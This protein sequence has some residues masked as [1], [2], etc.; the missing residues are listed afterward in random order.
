MAADL[1]D[2]PA[3]G[4]SVQ[5]CGEL[6]HSAQLWLLRHPG[7]PC[8]LRHQR[9]GRDPA[10]SLGVGCKTPNRQLRPW[11]AVTNGFSKDCARDAALTCVRSYRERMAKYS[12]MLTMDVWYDSIGLGKTAP[13]GQGRRSPQGVPKNAWR[14]PAN[15]ACSNMSFPNWF[16]QPGW[17]RRS[18]KIRRS[19][20][21]GANRVTMRCR[22][23]SKGL[24]RLSGDPPGRTGVFFWIVS[25][26]WTSHSRW[27]AS[28]RWDI[29]RHATFRQPPCICPIAPIRFNRWKQHRHTLFTLER[30]AEHRNRFTTRHAVDEESRCTNR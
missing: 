20:I 25:R 5:A 7:T 29:V 18:R 21:T 15:A 17:P 16:T 10:R 3:S 26:S 22:Q 30:L 9:P 28:Q 13:D 24:C 4:L 6:L 8:D 12:D 23:I 19:S 14:K 1:A 27:S 11:P 2:T